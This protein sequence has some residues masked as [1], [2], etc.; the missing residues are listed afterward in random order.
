MAPELEYVGVES[1][2]NECLEQPIDSE[3][4]H[5]VENGETQRERGDPS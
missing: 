1:R 5:S 2:D 4:F 3:K